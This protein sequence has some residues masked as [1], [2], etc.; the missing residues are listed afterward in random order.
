MHWERPMPQHEALYVQLNNI[1]ADPD[2]S[3]PQFGQRLRKRLAQENPKNLIIDLRHN[4]G[5]TTQ[6]YA[7]FLRT[8]VGFS[9]LPEKKV[10]VLIGR[11]T[12]SAAANLT[13]DLERLADPIFVGEA[14][15][16]CCNLY[17]DPA[18]FKL[19]FSK[20]RGRVSGVKWNLSA[21]VF[22]KRREISPEVPVQLTAQDYFR[23]RDPALETILQMTRLGNAT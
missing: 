7:E 6:T 11:A 13:M 3:L 8:V 12:Y 21:D 23:G 2:E 17:G 22:D 10:Y 9:Q 20:I 15:S 19:P 5:G 1:F 4:T 14:T 16:E 18:Q